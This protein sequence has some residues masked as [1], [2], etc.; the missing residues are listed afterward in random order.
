MGNDKIFTDTVVIKNISNSTITINDVINS[1]PDLLQFELINGGGTFAI[2]AH[3]SHKITVK[4]KP[5]YGG[6]GQ[7]AA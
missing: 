3:S 7:V 6:S 5:V 2:P 1:G 4:F